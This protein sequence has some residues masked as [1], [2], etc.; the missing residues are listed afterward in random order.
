MKKHII[1]ALTT[2][3]TG[4]IRY[5]GYSSNPDKRFKRHLKD[6]SNTHKAHWIQSLKKQ[7]LTPGLLLLEECKVDNWQER[8]RAWIAHYRKQGLPLTNGTEGGEGLCNPTQEVRDAIS[9]GKRGKAARKTFQHTPE[10]REAIS[11]AKQGVTHSD[12]HKAN[13]SKAHAKNSYVLLS[14]EGVQ[15]FTNNLKTFAL[16]HGLTV[17][18]L[19]R[20]VKGEYKHHKGWTGHKLAA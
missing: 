18:S 3:D 1:Y 12:T 2:P 20:V 6:K 7:G 10:T 19:S 17:A 16:E 14:P 8:E 9:R 15:H 5:I 4:Q 11:K 13:L